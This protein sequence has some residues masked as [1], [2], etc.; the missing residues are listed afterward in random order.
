MVPTVE[1]P[2]VTPS[3]DQV[4]VGFAC[5]LTVAVNC[6]V[7]PVI[8]TAFAGEMATP[9]GVAATVT[10]ALA[11]F[12]ASA[13]LVAVTVCVP[14][15][16]GAVYKPV[17]SMVP[18]L[19]FPLAILSTDQVTLVL[20][21][22]A[23]AA[24]NCSCAPAL[25][26]TAFWLSWIVTESDFGGGVPPVLDFW[27]AHPTKERRNAS[28]K[29]YLEKEEESVTSIKPSIARLPAGLARSPRIDVSSCWRVAAVERAN[30][31][32]LI[33]CSSLRLRML[34]FWLQEL[35]KYSAGLS[36]YL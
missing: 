26:V 36:K 32:G 18:V 6:W 7:A 9:A 2:P 1:F 3:T 14:A 28:R 30:G 19:E 12:V 10:V 35:N 16:A 8:R 4:I 24:L 17:A 15:S 29:R 33:S 21:V 27:L 22:P 34:C 25:S 13:A 31:G 23:T 20:L 5:P 11:L